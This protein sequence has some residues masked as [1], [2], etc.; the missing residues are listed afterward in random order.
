MIA[1]RESRPAEM[2]VQYADHGVALRGVV[3]VDGGEFWRHAVVTA[4]AVETKPVGGA[5]EILCQERKC[6]GP[7]VGF[8]AVHPQSLLAI[9]FV[10][11]IRVGILTSTGKPGW[12]G[13]RC[14]GGGSCG[15][16]RIGICHPS[17]YYDTDQLSLDLEPHAR[18]RV[19]GAV[20]RVARETGTGLSGSAPCLA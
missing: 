15:S 2:P 14:G 6:V 1:A 16:G 7:A 12:G 10:V 4:V 18:G 17:D 9:R 8:V 5:P 13:G 11:V 19:F 3:R 20:A